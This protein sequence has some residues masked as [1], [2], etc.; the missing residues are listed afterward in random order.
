MKALCVCMDSTMYWTDWGRRPKI[1]SA[2]MD[3][4]HRQTLLDKDLGWP[5][6]L[7]LDYLN[8]NRIY[9]CDSKEN[10]IESMKPDGTDRKVLI[11]GDIGNPY[12]VDVFEGHVYWSTKERGEVWKTDKFG[13]GNKVKVLTINPWLTQVR[14]YQEHRHNHSVLNPCR[15]MC[16]HLCLL[17]P[18][19]YSCTCPQGSSLMGFNSNECDAAIEPPVPMPLACRCRN[20]GTCYTDEG[21]LPKCK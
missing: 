8:G 9:W 6:G 10:V 19:G 7:T 21:G 1:E 17:R 16:S 20:G 4:Q 12:S 14:I 3:G 13:S 11:S 5:T 15:D 18:G 2:W